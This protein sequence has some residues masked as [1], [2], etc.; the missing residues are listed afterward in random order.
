M[1]LSECIIGLVA[2]GRINKSQAQAA[3]RLYDRHYK[4][5]RHQM[6]PM[7]AAGEASERAI[8]DL[9]IEIR[10]K[11]RIAAIQAEAQVK[12]L[13]EAMVV[14]G[15]GPIPTRWATDKMAAIDKK[16]DALRGV[17]FKD[18]G[19]MLEKHRRNLLGEVRNKSDL[20]DALRERFGEATGSV[21]AREMADVMGRVMEMARQRFNA[22]GGHIGKLESYVFPQ[23]HDQRLVNAVDVDTWRDFGPVQRARVMDFETGEIATG[24]RRAEILGAVHE[25]VRTDGAAR[26]SP[27]A[28]GQ[29][30]L[31]NRR[32]DPRVVHFDNADDWME[33]QQRFGGG[34]NVYNIFTNHIEHM[35]RDIALMEELGPNPSATV[36]FQK[37]W[38]R[39][40][41]RA[42]GDQKAIDNQERGP[43]KLGRLYDEITGASR[44]V[45][46]RR[47]ALAFS[48]LRAQQTAAK[49]GR[50]ILSAV[51]D[52][53]TLLHRSAYNDIPAMKTLGQYA[54]LW[55]PGKIS[56]NERALA[57]RLGLVTQEWIGMSSSSYR[58]GAEELT[59]E[60]SRR[61]ADGIIRVQG[62]ARHTRNAQWASGMETLSW[63]THVREAGFDNL[64][65]GT[66]AMWQRAGLTAAD[67]DIYRASPT[68][69]ER[70]SEWIIPT[71]IADKKIGERVLQ[72][73][74]T[75]T[76]SAIAMPDIHTRAMLSSLGAGTPQL[77]REI[78]KST[79]LF[80]GFPLSIISIHGRQM[81]D[82]GGPIG[83][84][85]YGMSLLALM[86]VGGALS[87]QLKAI[88]TGG[89]PL[90]MTDENN[91]T[92]ISP[93][94]V[95]KAVA[96]S[97]G[98]GLVG[99]LMYNSENSYG[100]GLPQTLAGPLLGQTVPNF[101]TALMAGKKAPQ[102]LTKALLA[103]VPGQ[104]LWYTGEAYQMLFAEHMRA[105]AGE[106]MRKTARARANYTEAEGRGRWRPML[107]SNDVLRAP[108][109]ANAFEGQVPEPKK[110]N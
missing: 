61:V 54:K 28:S 34:D 31:A 60:I 15:D 7:A 96:Q 16:I 90:P 9:E 10:Q 77:L 99:D 94:F 11:K 101:T 27:G 32:A 66:R 18:M 29:G 67:W 108:D 2:E 93:Q 35:L 92:G 17:M 86:A 4:T 105:L 8:R 78:A 59:G 87:T 48:A 20:V 79:F 75:E 91:P 65:P 42:K 45:E 44:V 80:K 64:E 62:L 6:S 83:S 13:D 3:E 68:V 76:D 102:K 57:A 49:M 52:F 14:A 26:L 46:N 41:A 107:G 40:S 100:G 30:A 22:A 37:D 1:S 58:Y 38:L 5:L 43:G 71:E 103:E 55:V 97:G 82:Q 63:L 23:S 106:D 36:A 69:T 84:A 21:N 89:D 50:A 85:K 74:L 33:Y 72:M 73:V 39:K 98:L 88:N 47:M 56:R 109:L 25:T 53:A 24:A 12:W 95:A 104:N 51:P 70:G 110:A 81:L 19:A